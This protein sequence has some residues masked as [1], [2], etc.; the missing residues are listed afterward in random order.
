METLSFEIIINAPKEKIWDV[1][2]SPETYPLWTRPFCEGSHIESDWKVDG[3]TY[4]L[5]G[6][7]EGMVSTID[8]LEEPTQVVFKHLGNY[9]NGKEDTESMEVKQWSGAFEKY[10]IIPM[11]DNVNR[12]HVEM[13]TEKNYVDMMNNSFHKGLEIVRKL[14]EQ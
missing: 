11:E 9:S 6:N 3:K 7:N 8:S 14:S 5:D 1:L 12:L 13:Q 4:F 2:W 10:F